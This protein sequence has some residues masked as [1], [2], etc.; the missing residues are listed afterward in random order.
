MFGSGCTS[1]KKEIVEDRKTK[2]PLILRKCFFFH[3]VSFSAYANWINKYNVANFLFF[4]WLFSITASTALDTKERTTEN[5]FPILCQP[6]IYFGLIFSVQNGEKKLLESKTL[7]PLVRYNGPKINFFHI[8]LCPTLL[9]GANHG[10]VGTLI[11]KCWVLIIE[12]RSRKGQK[13]KGKQ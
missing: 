8:F 2:K 10:K 5:G 9:I 1:K 4:L 12:K 6:A 7:P 11:I 13:G 3:C